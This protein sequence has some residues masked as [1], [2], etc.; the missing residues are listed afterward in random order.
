LRAKRLPMSH[1]N[2]AI[3]VRGLSKF[4]RNFGYSGDCLKELLIFGRMKPQMPLAF[5]GVPKSLTRLTDFPEF[6]T[7]VRSGAQP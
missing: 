3:S 7:M 4:Y 1:D 6:S 5:E 2:I